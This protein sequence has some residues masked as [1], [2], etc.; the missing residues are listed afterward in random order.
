MLFKILVGGTK[1]YG[2]AN[3]SRKDILK[4]KQFKEPS[5]DLE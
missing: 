5:S 1:S 2:K 4:K 3:M